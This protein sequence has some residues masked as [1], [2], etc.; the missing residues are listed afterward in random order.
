[1]WI[2]YTLQ[3]LEKEIDEERGFIQ[4]GGNS[5]T[6]L[7]FTS[8][9]VDVGIVPNNFLAFLLSDRNY[10]DCFNLIKINLNQKLVKPSGFPDF[11]KFVVTKNAFMKNEEILDQKYSSDSF[12]NKLKTETALTPKITCV[13]CKGQILNLKT[14]K[15]S[16]KLL[17]FNEI[18]LKWKYDL[19]KCVDASPTIIVF[20]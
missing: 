11:H 8:A 13:L 15:Y 14:S 12:Y 3:S 4:S 19:K 6:A 1:M 9:L 10:L 7:Q 16:R 17:G 20:K 2:K 5:F 18:K